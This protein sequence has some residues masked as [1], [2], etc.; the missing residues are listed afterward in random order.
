MVGIVFYNNYGWFHVIYV[1]S[2]QDTTNRQYSD[3]LKKKDIY[4]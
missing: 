4:Y 2:N 1:N 3:D